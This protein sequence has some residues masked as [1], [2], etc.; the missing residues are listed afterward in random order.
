MARKSKGNWAF[1]YTTERDSD[2]WFW[3]II[4]KVKI[5]MKSEEWH[6]TKKVHSGTTGG[7]GNSYNWPNSLHPKC[8]TCG[9]TMSKPRDSYGR[10]TA[11]M[12]VILAK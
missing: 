11:I 10:P 4:Y 2:G 9:K 7:G 3:A 1:A 12:N 8:P 5:T 6:I